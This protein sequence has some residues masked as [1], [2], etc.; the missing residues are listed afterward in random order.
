MERSIQDIKETINKNMRTLGILIIAR[1]IACTF[2][3][4][5][6]LVS[7]YYFITLFT[8]GEFILY[9]FEMIITFIIIAIIF[10]ILYA[11]LITLS[12]DFKRRIYNDKKILKK[13]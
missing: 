5:C 1:R 9:T 8:V 6:A 10:I 11:V 3:I 2:S 7:I 4:G 12:Q 13:L